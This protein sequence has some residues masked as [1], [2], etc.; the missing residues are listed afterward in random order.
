MENPEE[1]V[2]EKITK[3]S[4]KSK[5]HKKN[6][7]HSKSKDTDGENKSRTPSEQ[8]KNKKAKKVLRIDNGTDK[9]LSQEQIMKS[10]GEGN[11][12]L[13]KSEKNRKQDSHR[14]SSGA[15]SKNNKQQQKP[16]FDPSVQIQCIKAGKNRT[17]QQRRAKRYRSG[18]RKGQVMTESDESIDEM[19]INSEEWSE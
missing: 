9:T 5:K 15:N 13:I 14:N 3:S 16:K 8:K 2:K 6:K 12:T 1:Q 19:M 11:S 18:V 10:D 4:K 17:L 7:K